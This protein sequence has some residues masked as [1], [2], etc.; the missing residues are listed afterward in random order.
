M[1]HNMLDPIDSGEKVCCPV[2]R[3]ECQRLTLFALKVVLGIALA[4]LRN[5]TSVAHTC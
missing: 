2:F 5:P 1:D 4:T 3:A